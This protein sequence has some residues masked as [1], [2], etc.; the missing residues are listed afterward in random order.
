MN[1]NNN[2]FINGEFNGEFIDLISIE[3]GGIMDKGVDIETINLI[4]LEEP[5]VHNIMLTRTKMIEWFDF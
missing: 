5:A 3:Y 2:P 4:S 1:N